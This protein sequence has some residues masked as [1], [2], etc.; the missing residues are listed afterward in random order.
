MA[1]RQGKGGSVLLGAHVSVAGGYTNGLDYAVQIGA[2]CI[3]IFAKSPRQWRGPA[4]DTTAFDA[5]AARR[6]EL[7][8]GPVFTHTAYLL[9]LSTVDE[10][11]RTK[12]IAALADELVRAGGLAA[13]GVVTHVGNDPAQDPHRAAQRAADVVLAAYE[14]AGSAGANARLLLE[15]TAGAGH[16]FG[17]CFDELAAIIDRCGLPPTRLGVCFD[18]C[19]AFAYGMSV[20]NNQGWRTVVDE[21]SATFGLDRLGLIHANDCLFELGSRR[22]RHAW[23]GDGF[24]GADGFSAMVCTAELASVPAIT[25]MPG[26]APVKDEVNLGRLKA[27]RDHCDE[28]H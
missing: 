15:N 9:N 23:I 19:H 6:A 3:Q 4:I 12:T 28:A 26:E 17:C 1:R 2:E 20:T 18:T 14:L 5:F 13:D 10:D 25:E 11:L 8:F 22:D 7:G 21:M 24:I 27:F 16:S